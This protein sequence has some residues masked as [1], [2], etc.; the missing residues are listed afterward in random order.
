MA[1]TVMARAARKKFAV[2]G[3]QGQPHG[4]AKGFVRKRNATE[5]LFG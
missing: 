5:A 1:E 2:P 3:E 4:T